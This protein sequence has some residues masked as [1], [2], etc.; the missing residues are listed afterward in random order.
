MT[1]CL[2]CTINYERVDHIFYG[3]Y[4]FN[5]YFIN[6]RTFMNG[7]EKIQRYFTK[8]LFAKTHSGFPI[9]S[10]DERLKVFELL[11]VESSCVLMDILL[12][13]K[14]LSKRMAVQFSPSFSQHNS[15]RV[16]LHPV[17]SKLL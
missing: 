15:S 10:Y 8:R 9:P 1:T 7:I 14:I 3:F 13:Y 6:T 11:P 5:T 4:G 16:V 12:L 2:L 17:A